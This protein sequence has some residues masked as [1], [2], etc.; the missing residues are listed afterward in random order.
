[1]GIQFNGKQYYFKQARFCRKWKEKCETLF[2]NYV[3]GI[4]FE[5]CHFEDG[6][7]KVSPN[8]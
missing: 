1:M 4:T 2:S 8:I 5:S 6:L 7:W 3:F